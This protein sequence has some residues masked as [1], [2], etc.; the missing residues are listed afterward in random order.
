MGPGFGHNV[1]ALLHVFTSGFVH[2]FAPAREAESVPHTKPKALK[3]DE[4]T[5][6]M[7]CDGP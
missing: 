7:E 3:A 1:S 6:R 5:A 2:S 4:R